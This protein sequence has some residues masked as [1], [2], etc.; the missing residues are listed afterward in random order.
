MNRALTSVMLDP[1]LTIYS[2]SMVANSV[3]MV[4]RFVANLPITLGLTPFFDGTGLYKRVSSRLE[5]ILMRSRILSCPVT[6]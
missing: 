6:T 5:H 2:S 4:L 3:P 1:S